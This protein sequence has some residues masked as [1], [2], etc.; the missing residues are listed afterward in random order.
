MKI[1]DPDGME[2]DD[3]FSKTGKYLGSDDAKTDNVRIIDED[4]WNSISKDGKVDHSLGYNNSQSFSAGHGEMSK[5]AQLDVY[6]HYNP[7][8]CELVDM[9]PKDKGNGAGMRTQTVSGKTVIG[10][11]LKNNFSGM[12]VSDHAWEIESL[13]VHEAKHVS[14]HQKKA[15]IADFLYEES[16]LIEQFTHDSF[17]KCRPEFRHA[18]T[19]YA[20]QASLLP[21]LVIELWD[22]YAKK[23]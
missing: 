2:L 8:K 3:Y 16:A 15:F 14:D 17:A 4:K 22:P 23:H 7:T 20:K 11:F 13:F 19:E 12:N 10:I 6:N 5:K 21:S 1:V 18:M 9:M